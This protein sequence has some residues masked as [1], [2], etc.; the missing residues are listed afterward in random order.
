[1]HF[2]TIIFFFFDER[3]EILELKRI[4]FEI[5]LKK[6]RFTTKQDREDRKVIEYKN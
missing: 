3:N 1:M 2:T 4:I 6:T 5:F